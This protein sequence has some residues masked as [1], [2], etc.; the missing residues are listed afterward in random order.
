MG[1]TCYRTHRS[2]KEECDANINSEKL[3]VLKSAMV[4]STYYAAVKS[5]FGRVWAAVFLTSLRKGEFCYKDMDESMGPNEA[6]CP[7]G[8]LDLLSEPLND[9]ARDWRERCRKHAANKNHAASLRVGMRIELEHPL[10]F[11]DGKVRTRFEITTERHRGRNRRVF[12]CLNDGTHVRI[13]KFA[14]R[15]Y[16]IIP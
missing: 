5:P 13:T 15:P 7:I 11:T 8:I 2:P 9:H 12:K 16:R 1:W 6:K 14:S 10:K 3:T 4:G